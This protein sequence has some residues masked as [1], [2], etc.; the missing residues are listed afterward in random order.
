[1]TYQR[2]LKKSGKILLY[3]ILVLLL[4]VCILMIFINTRYGKRIVRNQVQSYL[5]NKLKTK[6]S[7]GT[8]D[9]SLPEWIKIKNVYLEDQQKDTL[10]YGEELTVDLSMLKLLRGNTDIQKILFRNIVINVNRRS[11]DS[12]FNYQFIV[13]AFSGNNPSTQN[14]DTSEMKLTLDRLVFDKVVFN[15]KDQYAGSDFFAVVKNLDLKMN[16]FQP[17][18]MDFRIDDLYANGVDFIMNTYKEQLLVDKP[19][20]VDTVN[21]ISY[22]LFITAGNIDLRDVNVL[23][24]NKISGL[25]YKNKVTHLIGRKILFDI[26]KTIATTDDLSLDSSVVIFSAPKALIKTVNVDSAVVM[27]MPWV[28]AAGKLGIHNTDIKYDDPNKAAAGGLDFAHLN[29]NNL[30]LSVSGFH[31]SQDTTAA[32]VDQLAFYDSSGFKLDT[33][34]LDLVFTDKALTL[35]NLYVKTP[36]TLI[37]R[38]VEVTYDSL[39]GITSAPQNSS[40]NVA[41]INSVIAFNDLFLIAP[42]LKKSLGGFA[43]QYLN[44]NTELKGSL[45]R[46]DIPYLQLSGLS[47]SRLNARGT[48]YNITD[49]N[50]FAFDLFIL[51]SNIIKRDLLK[52]IPPA[53]QALLEKLPEVFSLSGHFVGNKNDV[54]AELTTNAKDF[55]FSGKINLKNISNPAKLQYDVAVSN[56]S[57]DKNMISGF[58]PPEA[59]QNIELPQKISAQGK[60]TGNPD[61][62]TTDI[63]LNSSYGPMT[64]KGFIKNIKNTKNATYD[65]VVSTPGFAAGKLLKQDSILGNFAG[66][67]TAKGTGF[68]YKTMRSSIVADIAGVEYNKYNYKNVSIKAEFDKG[69]VTSNGMVNDSSLK[70]NYDLTANVSGEYPSVKG[71]IRID[72]VQLKQLNLYA[73][74]LNLSLTAAINSQNLKPRN[75]DASLL[76]DSIRMQSGSSFY[77]LDS[78]SL[79]GTS[80][81]GIDS[82]ILKAPFAEVH[83]GGAF[84]YDKVGISLQQYINNYYKIPGFKPSTISIPDQQLAFNGLY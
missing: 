4:L 59:L 65:L 73:D 38:S 30:Q 48:I 66:T 54:V 53:N 72:T 37:Q 51:P 33:T 40:V 36:H 8:I 41:L 15:F 18:R 82:I 17:D 2:I 55:V 76:L 12:V 83:A 64:I 24:D 21:N 22:P 62:I 49:T 19:V 44:I 63:R 50:R 60:L 28:F 77:Q 61:N 78:I 31:Y 79:V 10:I 52:F 56:L 26:G 34:R 23:L 20:V 71:L 16:K 70:L 7:I 57:V 27:P 3:I 68:D 67:F 81:A 6:V 43:N 75:L 29:V 46:V 1:M 13:N 9:Y 35:N 42:S 5:Q 45:Q 69:H 11:S 25:Y 58:M 80:S 47:G 32:V 39:G 84:D 74:T 14:T